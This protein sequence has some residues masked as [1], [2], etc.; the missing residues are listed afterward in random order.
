MCQETEQEQ[1]LRPFCRL[2]STSRSFR[3]GACICKEQLMQ[4]LRRRFRIAHLSFS[5]RST[6]VISTDA[7]VPDMMHA[8]SRVSVSPA[9]LSAGCGVVRSLVYPAA[10]PRRQLGRTA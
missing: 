8:V 5:P 4:A 2:Y 6:C 7:A 1:A 9:V 10:I 3:T